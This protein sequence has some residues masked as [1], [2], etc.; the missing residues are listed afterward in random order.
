MLIVIGIVLWILRASLPPINVAVMAPGFLVSEYFNKLMTG[1]T[2]PYVP[3]V[4]ISLA[5]YVLALIIGVVCF[6]GKHSKRGAV[7]DPQAN[8]KA[9][10]PALVVVVLSQ[11]AIC[12]VSNVVLLVMESKQCG[13]GF[14]VSMDLIGHQMDDS[15]LAYLIFAVIPIAVVGLVVLLDHF[16]PSSKPSRERPTSEMP[17]G[18]G[19]S[20]FS[21]EKVPSQ[22]TVSPKQ[23]SVA[24]NGLPA[25]VKLPPKRELPSGVK[26]PGKVGAS[27]GKIKLQSGSVPPTEPSD[28]TEKSTQ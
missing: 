4:G 25:G 10:W 16:V 7:S 5:A 9:S 17:K 1:N 20:H 8:Q 15:L 27:A 13:V 6:S 2:F 14:V 24:K 11:V 21:G 3:V 26:L 18:S 12:I 22:A 28:D 19:P 23:K